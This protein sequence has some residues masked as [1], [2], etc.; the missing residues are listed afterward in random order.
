MHI[1][2]GRKQPGW[3]VSARPQPTAAPGLAEAGWSVARYIP[4]RAPRGRLNDHL[5]SWEALDA[6]QNDP[7]GGL[8]L[9]VTLAWRIVIVLSGMVRP[10]RD[11]E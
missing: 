9:L 5:L 11:S 3:P 8:S 6:Q 4:G 7:G 1:E 2:R 10:T